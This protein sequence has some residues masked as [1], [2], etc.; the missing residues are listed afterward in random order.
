VVGRGFVRRQAASRSHHYRALGTVASGQ[1]FLSP[2]SF[3]FAR[4]LAIRQKFSNGGL[5]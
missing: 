1:K 2:D 5:K 3:L 4:L